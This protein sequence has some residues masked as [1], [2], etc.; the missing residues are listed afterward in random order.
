MTD[1][2]TLPTQ[3]ME[4]RRPTRLGSPTYGAAV[5]GVILVLAGGLWF[6]DIL[7]VVDLR[8][9]IVLPAALAV[10]GA[11]L[12]AGAWDG[13][14][15]GLVVAGVI[16]TGAVVAAAVAP[17][18]AFRGGIGERTF[19]VTQADDLAPRYDV[20]VGDLVLDLSGLSLDRV[21][22]V[23]ATVGAGELRVILPEDLAV[24]I[25]ASAGA[26]E[27]RL[28]GEQQDGL[29]VADTYTSDGFDG[30]SVRLTLDLDVAAGNIE[31]TR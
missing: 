21:A 16:L 29:S 28:L 9:A 1:V 18:N 7:D 13:P 4:D 12:V 10:V 6:L 8:A 22:E 5:L 15:S 20:G 24:D 31:V 17:A 19:V 23:D 27:V 25:D 14:H 3:T 11:A 2:D 26:G 30:A